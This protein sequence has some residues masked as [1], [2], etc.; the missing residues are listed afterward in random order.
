[1]WEG[2]KGIKDV[3]VKTLS[4][5]AT[6]GKK[7]CFLQE[8]VIMGQFVHPNIVQLYGIITNGDPVGSYSLASCIRL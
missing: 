6:D 2:S 7:I 8:A 4:D 3:A 1:M 5:N